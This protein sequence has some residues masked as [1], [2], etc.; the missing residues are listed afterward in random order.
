MAEF[1]SVFE[2]DLSGHYTRMF[3]IGILLCLGILAA[4]MYGTG[5]TS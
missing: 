3:I 5:T 1:V 2:S 4:M